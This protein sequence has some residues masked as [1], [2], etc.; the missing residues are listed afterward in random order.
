M[1][2]IRA[3]ASALSI[4]CFIVALP[5]FTTLPR[6]GRIAMFSELRPALAG[7]AAESPSTINSSA[8]S[9]WV[10][11]SASLSGNPVEP[12]EVGRFAAW[13]SRTCCR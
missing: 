8:S 5:A 11:Q 12:N 2:V 13:S 3:W 6:S 1:A 10:R 7:P 4:T 9:P